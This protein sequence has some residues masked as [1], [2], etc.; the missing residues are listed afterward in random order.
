MR[1]LHIKKG[2]PEIPKFHPVD[3][4]HAKLERIHGNTCISP[5][6]WNY[7]SDPNW[8]GKYRCVHTGTIKTDKGMICGMH[9]RVYAKRGW[10]NPDHLR[11]ILIEQQEAKAERA[12][13]RLKCLRAG[14]CL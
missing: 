3:G 9:A 8:H 5:N 1:T 4:I 12:K 14:K 7:A 2:A 11:E 10:I 6:L 13:A